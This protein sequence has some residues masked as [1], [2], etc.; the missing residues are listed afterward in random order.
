M[1]RLG[2]KRDFVSTVELEGSR[3]LTL[4]QSLIN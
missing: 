1:F 4:A 2:E 3:I